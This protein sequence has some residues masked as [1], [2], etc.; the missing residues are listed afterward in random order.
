MAGMA[1][2]F[3]LGH[4][5][6]AM[7]A[8]SLLAACAGTAPE[9]GV[10]KTPAT[11][12]TAPAQPAPT[13]TRNTTHVIPKVQPERSTPI[14]PVPRVDPARLVGL[15]PAAVLNLLGDPWLKRDE[16]PAQVWLYASGPCA[17][18]VFLYADP[19]SGRYVVRY[20]DAVPRSRIPISRD[21][22]FN[23]QLRRHGPPPAAGA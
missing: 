3:R 5:L 16:R 1:A 6:G 18:H 7:A 20:V 12:V 17:F 15:E 11:A 4:C 10:V 8:V 19:D 14:A 13:S 2:V 22:C 23:A 9:Q 21:D